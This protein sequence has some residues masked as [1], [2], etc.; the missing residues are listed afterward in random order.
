M[1]YLIKVIDF[2]KYTVSLNFTPATCFKQVGTEATERLGKSCHAQKSPVCNRS[3]G[4][5]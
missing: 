4:S 2:C 1:F 3:I 5:R